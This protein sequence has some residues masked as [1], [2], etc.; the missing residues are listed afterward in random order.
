M[1]FWARP[2]D[3]NTGFKEAKSAGRYRFQK[4]YQLPNQQSTINN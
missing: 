3:A 1:L 2:Q 4:A